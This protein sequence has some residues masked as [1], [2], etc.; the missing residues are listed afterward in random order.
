MQLFKQMQSF[1]IFA[2]LG[3]SLAI[4]RGQSGTVKSDGQPIPG[5][6]V[7]ATQGDRVLTTL[8]DANGAFTI[9]K[10]GPGMWTI[11]VSMFGFD[12]ARKDIQIGTSPV[13]I[14][15]SLQLR[16]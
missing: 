3:C 6:T 2:L 10:M 5:A 8:T 13:K 12:T 7:R 9:D 14:D 16:E 4:A 1:K 15:L 11:D